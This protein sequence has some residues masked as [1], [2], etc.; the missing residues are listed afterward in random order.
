MSNQ[1]LSKYHSNFLQVA[2]R[3]LTADGGKLFPLDMYALGIIQRAILTLSAYTKLIEED[4]FPNAAAL[5]RTYVDT[6][7]QIY[8]VYQVD[9]HNDF[10]MK[11][12]EGAQSREYK[13]RKGKRMTDS[14][15]H[16]LLSNEP[17]FDWV[18]DI[19]S[20]TS[21]FIHFS[22]KHLFGVISGTGS[23]GEASVVISDKVKIPDK[24]SQ[25]AE[26]VMALISQGILSLLNSWVKIKQQP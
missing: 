3:M 15:L 7:L 9:D 22:N 21:G 14:Y 20:E 10:I 25:E 1:S 2:Q 12:M 17:G 8:A 11:K 5:I 6:L 24:V 18:S 26:Q 16:G 13:D 19:Y 4:N 23:N